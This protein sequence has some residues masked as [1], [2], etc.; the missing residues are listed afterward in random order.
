MHN[1]HH[2]YA[3]IY[4]PHTCSLSAMQS[5]ASSG[6]S[7]TAYSWSAA[8]TCLTH[9]SSDMMCLCR[10]ILTEPIGHPWRAKRK[11]QDSWCVL[12]CEEQLM[13]EKGVTA[14]FFECMGAFEWQIFLKE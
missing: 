12:F 4:I 13:V 8:E 7:S 10:H 3:S 2:I 9:L 14:M 1:Y 6:P 5:A 11:N